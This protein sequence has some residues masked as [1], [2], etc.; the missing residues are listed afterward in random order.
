[1]PWPGAA[2][3]PQ[4]RRLRQPAEAADAAAATAVAARSA[5]EAM[6][7]AETSAAKTA[8]AAKAAAL[9][10][11]ADSADADA[12]TAMAEL[13]EAA[14]HQTYRDATAR[15]AKSRPVVAGMLI[16][17][18]QR[19]RR[20]LS[21][22]LPAP[23]KRAIRRVVPYRPR[24]AVRPPAP[25]IRRFELS[26]PIPPGGRVLA[27][28]TIRIEA[29]G[30]LYVPK[31]LEGTGFAGYEPDAA[32][33][34]LAAIDEV[35]ARAVFDVGANIGV[36]ALLAAAVTEAEVTGFEPTADIAEAFEAIVRANDLRCRVEAIALGASDGTATLQLSGKTDSSNSLRVGFRPTIGTVDVP[37]ERLDAYCARTGVRPTVLK[38]DTEATEPDV[39]RGAVELL[40]TTRPWIV[41]EVLAGRTEAALMDV[42]RPFGYQWFHITDVMPFT[43]TDVIAGDPTYRHLDWLFAPEP[44]SDRFWARAAA[45]RDSLAACRTTPS[46]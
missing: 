40:A 13:G 33:C 26:L 27:R 46:S 6:A 45:W 42:L 41:C 22:Y 20:A 14:A 32:A 28:P 4:R 38:V 17:I 30:R 7:L 8:A 16:A 39:F 10:T 2:G 24:T 11:M 25:A 19:S 29:P 35:G 44:P 5:L 21:R 18:R 3:S 34:F 9:S 31:I 15:A 37:L 36:F 23:V 1:M 43:P 12:D